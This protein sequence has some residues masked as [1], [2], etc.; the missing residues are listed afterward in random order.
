[1]RVK[2]TIAQEEDGGYVVRCPWPSHRETPM[3]RHGKHQRGNRVLPWSLEDSSARIAEDTTRPNNRCS[4]K[5]QMQLSCH[6]CGGF[7]RSYPQSPSHL[8]SAIEVLS[9]MT[10]SLLAISFLSPVTSTMPLISSP[11]RTE[12]LLQKTESAESL[13]KPTATDIYR[14]LEDERS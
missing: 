4:H 8:T 3:R 2:I 7:C 1:M 14:G 6:S 5:S 13:G 10:C 12:E 9:Q 11:T